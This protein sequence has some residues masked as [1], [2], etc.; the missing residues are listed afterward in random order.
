[1]AVILH[2][3]A[4]GIVLGCLLGLLA[5]GYSLVYGVAKLINFAHGEFFVMGGYFLLY[6]LL[7]SASG[8]EMQF[9]CV[10]ATIG[11]LATISLLAGRRVS[12]QASFAVVSSVALALGFMAWQGTRMEVPIALAVVIAIVL[13]AL[14]GIA[15]E[16]VVYRPLEGSSRLA[17]L[18]AA[19]GLSVFLQG[20]MQLL[21]G[22]ERRS[23]PPP[24]IEKLERLPI[25][26]GLER[27]FTGLDVL[28]VISTLSLTL[29]SVYFFRSTGYG[30]EMRAAAA[31]PRLAARLGVDV[32]RT[33]SR[34]FGAGAAL[35]GLTAFFFVARQHILEPT[36]GYSQ[37]ILAFCAAV[38]GGIGRLGGALLGGLFI[39][40]VLSVLPLINTL[41]LEA[42]LP[43]EVVERLPSL[44][45]SDWGLGIVYLLMAI[46]LA[47]RP[48][49]LVAETQ[50]REV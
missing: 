20:I 12:P 10:V 31:S 37:G 4:N 22:T 19:L 8:H 47:F 44:N 27:F 49:G 24:V 6:L 1:M 30:I 15:A 18:V 41:A 28:I 36:L 50:W 26:P 45:P 17:Y 3:L 43:P 46:V 38:L 9:S 5:V 48:A 23:F 14:L 35:A 16:F 40:L 2:A 13:G 11:G 21:F 7:G 33:R 32:R 29:L 25:P 34:V 42:W 39:G